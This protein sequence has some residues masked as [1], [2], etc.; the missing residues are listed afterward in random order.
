MSYNEEQMREIFYQE[1]KEV[2]EH[3]DSCILIL[4]RTPNDIEIIKNLFREVHTLKGSSGVFGIREIADL[5]H[6]AE[7]LLDRMRNGKLTPDEEVF[8][9]LLRCFDRLKEMMGASE[10][11]ESICLRQRRYYPAAQSIS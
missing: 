11:R 3:I 4:E 7:D 6:H 8:S 9:A 5:T 2:F 1:M 10:R